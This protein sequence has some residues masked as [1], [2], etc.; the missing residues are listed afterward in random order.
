MNDFSRAKQ[1][2]ARDRALAQTRPHDLPGS[3]QLTGQNITIS[4]TAEPQKRGL[5]RIIAIE[6]HGQQL[7]SVT[8]QSLARPFRAPGD[9]A[10]WFIVTAE[11]HT[12][13]AVPV[14][15]LV[16]LSQSPKKAAQAASA[17]DARQN[18]ENLVKQ[19]EAEQKK[20]AISAAADIVID[21]VIADIEKE[22]ASYD[23]LL[24][25]LSRTVQVHKEALQDA[26]DIVQT[27]R[28][29]FKDIPASTESRGL[30]A[31]VFYSA[32][33]EFG[34]GTLGSML[35][36]G[37]SKLL[38]RILLGRSGRGVI[39]ERARSQ[40]RAKVIAEF[41]GRTRSLDKQ[42][43]TLEAAEQKR[44]FEVSEALRLKAQRRHIPLDQ[45]QAAV[46]N[47]KLW[48]IRRARSEGLRKERLTLRRVGP[49]LE[50]EKQAISFFVDI[51]GTAGTIGAK[52][53]QTLAKQKNRP[54]PNP[55]PAQQGPQN[56]ISRPA[57]KIVLNRANLPL[58]VVLKSSV[59]SAYDDALVQLESG[60]RAAKRALQ[61]IRQ[62]AAAGPDPLAIARLYLQTLEIVP[63]FIPMDTLVAEFNQEISD[64]AEFKYRLTGEY[65]LVIW[66]L[67]FAGKVRVVYQRLDGNVLGGLWVKIDKEKYREIEQNII[68]HRGKYAPKYVEFALRRIIPNAEIFRPMFKYLNNRFYGGRLN[69][70]DVA[71]TF[72]AFPGK[73]DEIITRLNKTTKVDTALENAVMIDDNLHM[74]KLDNEA[75]EE[76]Q[77][78]EADNPDPPPG[79]S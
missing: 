1:L 42:I 53:G 68:K 12:D 73:V 69:E 61:A 47:D 76:D 66:S 40:A 13:G 72:S 54:S 23:A 78:S 15:D 65:E 8:R 28:H 24:H 17:S 39:R 14:G 67:L 9:D 29:D 2:L 10:D 62:N 51:D 27:K 6:A 49:K 57:D 16:V 3:I 79:S 55:D 18:I 32:L 58:D 19:L 30:L 70:E 25:K 63:T 4:L 11:S 48:K 56:K 37:A 77:E 74:P 46:K 22:L 26:V 52:L 38:R 31:A 43:K 41:K 35:T 5:Y 21:L 7:N 64:W 44:F 60:I 75:S 33:L 20:G 59:G 50:E 36:I 34:A 45:L 71:E